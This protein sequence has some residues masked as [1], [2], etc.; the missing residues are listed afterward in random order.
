[1]IPITLGGSR[2]DGPVQGFSEIIVEGWLSP[3]KL[4]DVT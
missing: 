1:V 2:L 3:L 4:I